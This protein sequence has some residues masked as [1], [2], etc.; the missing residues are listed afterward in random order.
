MKITP[1]KPRSG[2]VKMTS[3]QPGRLNRA[4]RSPRPRPTHT[5]AAEGIPLPAGV[6]PANVTIVDL[7]ETWTSRSKGVTTNYLENT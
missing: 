3:S 4:S 6:N 7:G 5:A 2:P 1:R